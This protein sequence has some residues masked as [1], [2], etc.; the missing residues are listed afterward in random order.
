MSY[1]MVQGI[2][3]NPC[4]VCDNVPNEALTPGRL[5]LHEIASVVRYLYS[6][7]FLG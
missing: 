2:V 7:N 6:T 1:L 5:V 4:M 3:G